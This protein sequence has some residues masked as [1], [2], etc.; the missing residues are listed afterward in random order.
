MRSFATGIRVGKG[1]AFFKALPGGLRLSLLELANGQG[2]F[3]FAFGESADTRDRLS[4]IRL[5]SRL[6]GRPDVPEGLASECPSRTA[7]EGTTKGLV[8]NP[9]RDGCLK[10]GCDAALA[11]EPRFGEWRTT[12]GG[13]GYSQIYEVSSA[14]PSASKMHSVSC[15]EEEAARKE[16]TRE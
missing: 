4:A 1:R 5:S 15:E 16:T 7:D 10:P 9:E 14:C 13:T 6:P 12:M 2:A 11:L 8:L 3:C